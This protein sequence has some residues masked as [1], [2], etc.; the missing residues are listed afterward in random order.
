MKF[1][2]LILF[3]I[4]CHSAN[5]QR[6]HWINTAGIEV[7]KDVATNYYTLS[8]TDAKT[9]IYKNFLK[10]ND[11]LCEEVNYPT[12][13]ILSKEG[14]Y[15]LY[16]NNG[17]IAEKG[18][19]LNN[20]KSN[21]W[22]YYNQ[23]GKLE[24]TISFINGVKEG[25]QTDYYNNE[26]PEATYRYKKGNLISLIELYDDTEASVFKEDT[27]EIAVYSF[28]DHEAEFPGGE[29][30]LNLFLGQNSNDSK[31]SN[32]T[33]YLSFNVDSKGVVTEI[34]INK[35]TKNNI[36]E[37]YLKRAM[38]LVAKMPQWEPAMKRGR[39]VKSRKQIKIDL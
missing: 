2:V 36:S 25:K 28:T 15:I 39:I 14:S 18:S 10:E 11:S 6:K 29:K 16:F 20:L 23:E 3:I 26:K 21:L 33:I 35:I 1:I 32:A 12:K 27:S 13:E 8:K 5:A 4:I 22:R 24:K 38:K 31:E 9:Y 37:E 17:K 19:Y 30:A 7:K 34:I